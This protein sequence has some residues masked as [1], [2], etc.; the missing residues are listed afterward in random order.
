MLSAPGIGKAAWHRRLAERGLPLRPLL[1]CFQPP[2]YLTLLFSFSA[3]P[4]DL[5]PISVSWGF[6]S[7]KGGDRI[8]AREKEQAERVE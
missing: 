3:P 2:H 1:R 4:A 6:G 8:H 5:D 7:G